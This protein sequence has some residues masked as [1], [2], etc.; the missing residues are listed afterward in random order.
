MIRA[1]AE[2]YKLFFLVIA[3]QAIYVIA[4]KLTESSETIL[5]MKDLLTREDLKDNDTFKVYGAVKPGTLTFDPKIGCY[6][7][8]MTDFE[9]DIS[10]IYRGELA[11]ET[12]EGETMIITGYFPNI[13]DRSRLVCVDFVVNHSL[14]VEKWDSSFKSNSS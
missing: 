6:K 9:R 12:R 2:L 10:V 14:E 5:N 4:N 3:G 1:K 8:V 11:F 7:F 13:F